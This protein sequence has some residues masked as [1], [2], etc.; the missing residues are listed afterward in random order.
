MRRSVDALLLGLVRR[1]IQVPSGLLGRHVGYYGGVD[2]GFG[3]GGI[4]FT[5]GEWRGHEFAYN[6]AVTRVN[7]S[8]I[9]TTYNDPAIVQRNTIANRSRISYNGGPGGIQHAATSEERVADRDQHT[10]P[11]ASKHIMRRLQRPTSPRMQRRMADTHRTRL[12][13]SLW[14]RKAWRGG[15]AEGRGQARGQNYAEDRVQARDKKCAE[16]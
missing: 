10:A 4:G 12:S 9:R 1:Q 15:C 6:T 11:Q 13:P 3:Y 2:Y 7:Q 16:G 5:G 14:A 8:V